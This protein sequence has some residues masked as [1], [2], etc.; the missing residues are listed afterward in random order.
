M[1]HIVT[2]QNFS[3]SPPELEI[4]LGDCVK[5]RNTDGVRHSAKRDKSPLFDTGLLSRNVE[6][7]EINFDDAG[8]LDYYCEPH[9]S[10]HGKII[11]NETMAMRQCEPDVV[12]SDQPANPKQSMG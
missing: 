3:F 12:V 7:D 10:M 6:S 2:I 4:S 9:P 11:V 5:W 8:E 1:L